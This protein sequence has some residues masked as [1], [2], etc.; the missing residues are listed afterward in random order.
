MIN[1][2]LFSTP[3][4]VL[5]KK[6]PGGG[7]LPDL[8]ESRVVEAR[9]EGRLS[10]T[11]LELMIGD[12]K[13]AARTRIPLNPGD[14]VRLEVMKS[15]LTQ[16]LRFIGMKPEAPSSRV[17]GFPRE[18]GRFGPHEQLVKL[19]PTPSASSGSSARMPAEPRPLPILEQLK[20]LTDISL[21]G[22]KPDSGLDLQAFLKGG[23]AAFEEKLA[24][25]LL[26]G[27]PGSTSG[28][29][30]STSVGAA[31]EKLLEKFGERLNEPLH[32]KAAGAEPPGAKTVGGEAGKGDGTPGKTIEIPAGKAAETLAGKAARPGGAEA[33]EPAKPDAFRGV[34]AEMK[35]GKE[36]GETARFSETMPGKND[37]PGGEG[38]VRNRLAAESRPESL[39]ENT[40]PGKPESRDGSTLIKPGA[41]VGGER[42]QGIVDRLSA[43]M[44]PDGQKALDAFVGTRAVTFEEKVSLLLLS[45]G[46]PAG[47]GIT[48][49][50]GISA[51]GLMSG[52]S[53]ESLAEA[54]VSHLKSDRKVMGV[55]DRLMAAREEKAAQKGNLAREMGSLLEK[56][57]LKSERFDGDLVRR[58]IRS[59][60]F[61]WENRIAGIGSEQGGAP[62]SELAQ[63]DLKAVAM[64]FASL[65]GGDDEVART[66][67]SFVD[68]VDRMQVLNMRSFEESGKYLLPLPFLSDESWRFGQLLVDLGEKEEGKKSGEGKMVRVAFLLSMSRLG[69][70]RADFA[71][72]NKRL[73]GLFTVCDEEVCRLVREE[74]SEL[75]KRLDLH[76]FQVSGIKCRVESPGVLANTSLM[77]EIVENRDG[78]VR[79]VI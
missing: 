47:A 48:E 78:M 3:D 55:H 58:M 49:G 38:I 19:A 7:R 16:E 32:G 27:G 9:V 73:S 2:I 28:S 11:L 64:K 77:D 30:P 46:G 74:S 53:L 29:F 22:R 45:G 17:E 65:L 18:F 62:P 68:G 24:A 23:E 67:Q 69:D 21:S 26:R 5:E 33:G 76:G 72:L 31:L 71:I 13:V 52:D 40:A 59:S 37:R 61:T 4:L 57:A 12:V 44:S 39:R 8:T 36:P 43:R 56:T 35:P 14:M 66:L 10:P 51:S 6:T 50:S 15:D 41:D 34:D 42:L 79:V 1:R 54:L 20:T 25:L 75:V 70:V 60:G 63:G